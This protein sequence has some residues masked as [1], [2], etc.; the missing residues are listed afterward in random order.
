MTATKR[1][2]RCSRPSSR[3][4]ST[5]RAS[6]TRIASTVGRIE[7]WS[8][9]PGFTALLLLTLPEGDYEITGLDSLFVARGTLTD[10]LP[11]TFFVLRPGRSG[12]VDPET[13]DVTALGIT[14]SR[15]LPRPMP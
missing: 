4:D 12:W 6:A 3:S 5:C 15:P 2:T 7:S 13:G 10:G 8:A 11:F 9:T 14:G 1:R